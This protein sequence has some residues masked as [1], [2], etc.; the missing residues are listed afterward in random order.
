MSAHTGVKRKVREFIESGGQDSVFALAARFGCS[1]DAVYWALYCM[2]EE[3]TAAPLFE[4]VRGYG[5]P[6]HRN[7][8][9]M[10]WGAPS[11]APEIHTPTQ[12][13]QHALQRRTALE[14]VWSSAA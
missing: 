12:L 3:G 11:K 1:R 8:M 13:V 2:R 4:R 7:R 5:A 10:V 6:N 9:E 14:A